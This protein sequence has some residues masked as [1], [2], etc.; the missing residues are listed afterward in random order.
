MNRLLLSTPLRVALILGAAFLVALVIANVAAFKLIENELGVRA[1][2]AI[3]DTFTVISRAYG[4]ADQTD[5]VES[6][7]AHAASTI[8]HEKIFALADETGHVIVGNAAS[9]PSITG[10]GTV[11]AERLGTTP[12]DGE[13]YRIFVGAVGTVR[14]MVGSSFAET[15][16]I[17]ALTRGTL[18]WASMSIL[19]IVLVIGIVLALSAQ[20]RIDS[21]AGTMTRV[22]HGEL[23]ARIAVGRRGDDIDSLSRQVNA[24]LDRL[25]ALV[26]GMRHVSV[27]IAH[28]LKTPL[29]RLAITIEDATD[30]EARGLSVAEHL[31][32][33]E[34]EIQRIN[35]TFDAL[36]RIAQIEAGA[37]RARF[38][39][40]QLAQILDK[41]VDAYADVADEA[42]Q[43]LQTSYARD[44]PE[45]VGDPELLTQLCANLV[46][47]SIRHCPT[48]TTIGIT[49]AVDE[50]QVVA[51]FSDNGP[52]IPTAEHE[53]V[54]QRLYRLEKSRTTSG[55]GLGLS[56]VKAI[57]ELH[58]ASIAIADLAPGLAIS[59][60]FPADGRR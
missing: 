27:N 53:K 21:I 32:Q 44:L 9:V 18:A 13:E 35:S 17:A 51:T 48:G 12:G 16:A 19:V 31:A 45:I 47:N 25:T 11:G 56:L 43:T 7:R 60:R 59:V 5:L 14:L 42:G 38:V 33:A 15:R 49:V 55:N 8:D 52:G 46:E 41:I 30:A 58:G 28:D 50:M 57:A 54:F 37:R 1:D 39:R 3:S 22:G 6:V 23:A 34:G 4:D 40:L 24:A 2:Q 29:N 10:W 20:R 26:E 36:L